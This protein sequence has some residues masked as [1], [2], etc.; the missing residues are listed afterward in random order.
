MRAQSF[1]MRWYDQHYFCIF[2]RGAT[3]TALRCDILKKKRPLG[4]VINLIPLNDINPEQEKL[5]LDNHPLL[6]SVYNFHHA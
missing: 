3:S 2:C 5:Q 6:V 1:R 4:K